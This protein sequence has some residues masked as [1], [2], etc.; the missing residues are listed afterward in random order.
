MKENF[1]KWFYGELVQL[2]GGV[3]NLDGDIGG[4]TVFGVAYNFWPN[5]E[6]WPIVQSL[7]KAN[8]KISTKDLFKALDSP[9]K[10]FYKGNFWDACKLDSIPSGVDSYLMTA[11]IHNGISKPCKM[12]QEI[13]GVTPDGSIGNKTIAAVAQ[14][15]KDKEAIKS[16]LEQL[17]VK[18]KQKYDN[19][20]NKYEKSF[21]VRADKAR[22]FALTLIS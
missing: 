12:L 10:K 11:V 2:E 4:Y 17:H 13:V 16:I 1:D 3:A 21:M 20:N 7:L 18:L 22:D 6:G 14:M 8:P 9:L 5:W 15:A 19:D